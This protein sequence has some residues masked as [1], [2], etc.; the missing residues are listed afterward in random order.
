MASIKRKL[1]DAARSA[2]WEVRRVPKVRRA[3]PTDAWGAQAKLLR[4]V[5]RPTILDV[6]AHFGETL[7]RYAELFPR[8]RIHSFEPYPASFRELRRVAAEH[9]PAEAHELALSD[10]AGELTFHASPVRH[11][12][13]S[14]LPRPSAGRRYYPADADLP[15]TTTVRSETVD[16]FCDAH[17][18]ERIDVLKMDVQGGELLV[19]NGAEATLR[20]GRVGLI[21]TEVIFVPHYEGGVLFTELSARLEDLGFS[22]FNIYDPVSATNGQLR[23]ANAIFVS[24]ELRARAVDASPEEP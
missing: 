22:I 7:V 18:I 10:R 8:A 16:G 15:E 3:D 17:G 4:D 19:L 23:F 5:E 2:G 24:E 21:Y 14:L 13:N 9:P 1:V 6:G 20:A 11:A 12:T